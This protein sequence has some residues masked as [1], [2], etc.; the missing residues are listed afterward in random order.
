M[1]SLQDDELL[2]FL[3][4]AVKLKLDTQFIKKIIHEI[5]RRKLKIEFSFKEEKYKYQASFEELSEA[6]IDQCSYLI[7]KALG[8]MS[9]RF[10]EDVTLSEIAQNVCVTP[11][12]LS[13]LF[14]QVT[15]KSFSDNLFDLRMEK[16]TELLKSST[17]KIYQIG[18]SVGYPNSR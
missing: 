18:E 1:R 17:L 3:N 5:Y 4:I 16:A 10:M 9:L 11:S 12:Y 7:K 14:R 8:I 6:K 15:G 2:I 13:R